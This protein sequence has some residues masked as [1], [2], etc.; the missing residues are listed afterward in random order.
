MRPFLAVMTLAAAAAQQ[1]PSP[2]ALLAAIR[3]KM[4]E[5][6]TNL[7]NY[8][9]LL[10]IERSTG[11]EKS[12]HLRLIDTLHIEVGYVDGKEL[13][14][15]PGQKFEGQR[16][17]EML[18]GGA[19]GTGDFA[20]HVRSL[21]LSNSATFTFV[22]RVNRDGHDRFEFSYHVPRARSKYLL[23]NGLKSEVVGY[24]GSFWV[25]A[26]SLLLKRLEIEIDDI[27]PDLHVRRGG[28]ILRYAMTRIGGADFLLPLSS[29]LSLVSAGGRASR[30]LT[31]F[32]QCHQYAGESVVSFADPAP[33]STEA[34]KVVTQVRLPAGLLVEMTLRTALDGGRAAI[35][36]PVAA[37]VSKDVVSS[38]TVVLPKGA[39]VTGRVTRLG[40]ME[41][42]RVSWQM[43]GLRLSTVEFDDKRAEFTGILESVALASAQITVASGD[44]QRM[45]GRKAYTKEP[46][47][48][49]IFVKGNSLHIP[50]GAHMYW[51]TVA[52]TE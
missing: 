28:S 24:H 6:L 17:E 3:Q 40:K 47:E 19:V 8:T 2:D 48:G 1:N 23:G 9:C 51:R 21:F 15:W 36:D 34:R 14:A 25:D 44:D 43:A 7:P 13:Y 18:S 39:K 31:R 30:N 4:R 32:E 35:G 52:E 37:V 45:A 38:G 16:L 12:R 41:G 22:G 5:N 49:I 29:E 42:G 20:L 27:P 26:A 33:T 10:T 11:P 50:A 46:G